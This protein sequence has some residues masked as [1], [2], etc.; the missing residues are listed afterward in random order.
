MKHREEVI[1]VRSTD[2]LQKLFS[3]HGIADKD[4][5][6]TCPGHA[7]PHAPYIPG[8]IAVLSPPGQPLE[9]NPYLRCTHPAIEALV[10]E[11]MAMVGA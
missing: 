10:D 7:A 2:K 4:I 9:F 11:V 5:V 3:K 1:T 6:C 8:C